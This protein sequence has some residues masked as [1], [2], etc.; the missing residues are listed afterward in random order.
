MILRNNTLPMV[1][2]AHCMARAPGTLAEPPI[3]WEVILAPDKEG[4][5]SVW[6]LLC[7]HHHGA[8]L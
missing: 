7:S 2:C 8:E 3:G 5:G 6:H 4:P 1:Q